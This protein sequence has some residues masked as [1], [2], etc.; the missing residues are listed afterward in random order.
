MVFIFVCALFALI[1]ALGCSAQDPNHKIV[2]TAQNFGCPL[3]DLNGNG[4]VQ[5][6]PGPFVISCLYPNNLLCGY[7][8]D[9]GGGSIISGCPAQGY[10]KCPG[11]RPQPLVGSS[12]L[13]CPLVGPG[14][15]LLTQGNK[16]PNSGIICKYGS[17]NKCTY[18]KN[19]T[20]VSAGSQDDCQPTANH[21]PSKA[22]PTAGPRPS[23]TP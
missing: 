3:V 6:Q 18:A 11:C 16:G 5:T 13:V 19:G 23:C 8:T 22:C 4:L 1:C 21:I 20:L 2:L 7:S 10:L 15:A 17:S 12:P 14:Q 9:F